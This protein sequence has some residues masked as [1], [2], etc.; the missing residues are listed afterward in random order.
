[1]EADTNGIKYW[2]YITRRDPDGEVAMY[3]IVGY[4]TKEEAL[5]VI[6]EWA[7]LY[8][9]LSADIKVGRFGRPDLDVWVRVF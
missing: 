7:K 5:D 4:D 8:H 1:M 3:P 2:P 6:R 9:I